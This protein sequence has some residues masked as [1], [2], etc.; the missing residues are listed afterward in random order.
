MEYAQHMSQSYSQEMSQHYAQHQMQQHYHNQMMSMMQMVP[1]DYYYYMNRPAS[2]RNRRA[3][4][5]EES[6]AYVIDL[7]KV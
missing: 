3:I 5:T 1:N 6:R 7:N 2:V 4:S